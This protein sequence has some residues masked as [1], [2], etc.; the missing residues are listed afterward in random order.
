MSKSGYRSSAQRATQAAVIPGAPLPAPVEL[1]P[2][3]AAIWNA[4]VARL[5]VDWITIENKPL[6][7]AYCRHAIYSE[8]FAQDIMALRVTLEVLDSEGPPAKAPE[9]RDWAKAVDTTTA[10]LHELHKMHAL[11]TD[12]I[13]ALATKMRFTQQ[14]R[15]FPDKAATKSRQA[16]PMGPKPWR[17]WGDAD[18]KP[19]N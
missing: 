4:I 8:R 2:E 9:K 1:E 19:A 17:D 5:P 14:S 11:E 15:Y 13:I 6:L 10:K 16:P 18:D 7:I 12:R 3:C